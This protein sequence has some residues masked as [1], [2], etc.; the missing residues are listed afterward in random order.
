MSEQDPLCVVSCEVPY[1]IG[2]KG[3]QFVRAPVQ[4]PYSKPVCVVAHAIAAH[5]RSQKEPVC[6]VS[7][8]RA[9]HPASLCG[10]RAKSAH[11]RSEKSARGSQSVWPLVE[12][13]KKSEGGCLMAC[14]RSIIGLMLCFKLW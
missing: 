4:E 1:T 11:C 2:Q 10:S 5:C 13:L 14:V 6:V 3:I 8:A 12:E 9:I 7:Y